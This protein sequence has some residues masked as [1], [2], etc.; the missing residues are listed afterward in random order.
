[1]EVTITPSDRVD[2]SAEVERVGM[3]V[4]ESTDESEVVVDS[5]AEEE[6]VFVNV[7]EGVD[8]VAEREE[9]LAVVVS[10]CA[11]VEVA[12]GGGGKS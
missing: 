3:M 4:V 11:V 8:V 5:D 10:V 7:A 1:M 9:T 6:A 2:T 12:G